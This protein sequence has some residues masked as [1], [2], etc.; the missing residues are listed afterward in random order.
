MHF[1]CIFEKHDCDAKKN[2]FKKQVSEQN[3]YNVSDFEL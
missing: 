2:I 1:L 3:F